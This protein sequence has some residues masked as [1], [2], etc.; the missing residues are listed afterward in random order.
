MTGEPLAVLHVDPDAQTR[1]E[2]GTHIE[3]HEDMTLT[4]V[5]SQQRALDEASSGA[6]DCV[7]SAY[8]L[9]DGTAFEL[10]SEL[11][12]GNPDVGCILYT[13]E[14]LAE[15]DREG[16][17]DIVV[18]YLSKRMPDTEQRLPDLIRSVVADRLQ[19]GYPVPEDE[20]ARLDAL[21]R[22]SFEDLTAT[23]SFDRILSLV[24]SHFGV[25][26]AFVGM[27]QASRE[28]LIACKGEQWS[29]F[30]REN[31]IC[32]YAILESD[33]TVIEDVKTDPRFKHNEVLDDLGIRS[34]A[35]ANLT[36]RDGHVIG[37]LCVVD[38][39]PHSFDEADRTNL[40][41]FAAE[42][43]EQLELRA[44]LPADKSSLSVNE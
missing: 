10:F 18:E 14:G 7:V 34:Y 17:N 8:D 44:H 32:T 2:G 20:D 13:A 4:S 30:D 24:K 16:A 39:E 21:D 5:S 23:S 9:P 43:M 38:T 41:R 36:T 25:N 19:V 15:I 11:R 31:T 37:E 1:D 40:S 26:A 33:V 27:M 42:V 12:E 28:N 22:Y 35:G 3:A 29:M 6:F